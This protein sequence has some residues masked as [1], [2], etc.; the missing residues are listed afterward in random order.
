[1]TSSVADLRNQ[2][3]AQYA[4]PRAVRAAAIPAVAETAPEDLAFALEAEGRVIVSTPVEAAVEAA[5]K[6]TL[7]F[8]GRLVEAES[9]NLNGAFWTQKDLEFGLPTVAHGPLNWGHDAKEIVGALV[10]PVM[11]SAEQAANQNAGP[12]IQTGARFWSYLNPERANMLRKY[13]DEGRAWFSMECVAEK[14]ECR[15]PNGCGQ[16]MEY[17]D[18][19]NRTERAC[20]HVRER[21]SY[22]RFVNPVF[23]GA[24]VIVPPQRPGWSNANITGLVQSAERQLEAADLN[25]DGLSDGDAV[26]MVAAILQWAKR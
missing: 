22:R 24:A 9:A 19:A 23:Q 16:V 18:A 17:A 15:G 8:R 14:I 12:H 11:V 1:V 10:D 6:W 5:S 21:S 2:F 4:R 7:D 25:V 26:A 3:R 20:E 13:I